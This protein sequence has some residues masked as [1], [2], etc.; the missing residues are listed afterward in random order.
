V[1]DPQIFSATSAESSWLRREL[2]TAEV[3]DWD[4]GQTQ[5][6]AAAKGARAGKQCTGENVRGTSKHAD[7]SPPNRSLRQRDVE[8]QGNDLTRKDAPHSRRARLRSYPAAPLP[9]NVESIRG[10]QAERQSSLM[11]PFWQAHVAQHACRRW[12]KLRRPA[13]ARLPH[14]A[15]AWAAPVPAANRATTQ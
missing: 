6:G 13:P 2:G 14:T 8:S 11:P 15:P 7:H 10:R 5:E 1:G 3:A 9:L 12:W 4:T